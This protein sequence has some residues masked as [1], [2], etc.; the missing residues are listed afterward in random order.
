M[1][2]I[3]TVHLVYFTGTGGTA[4]VA[5][6]FEKAFSVYKVEVCK[7]KLEAKEYMEINADL[8]VLFFPVY[9]FNAPAPIDEWITRAPAGNGRAAAVISVS[10]GGEI[11]PNTAC[12]ADVIKQLA[13]K[14]YDVCYESMFVMPSNFIISYSDSLSAMLLRILPHKSE[15]VVADILSGK[16][17]RTKPY[18]IDRFLSKIGFIEK[19]Y[20]KTFGKKLKVNDKCVGCLWCADHC[21]RSNITMQ[22][23]QPTFGNRCVICLCC[24]YGCPQKAIVPGTGKFIVI[25]NGYD[26]KGVES[27]TNQLTEFPPLSKITNGFL[28]KGVRA[29]LDD[30]ENLGGT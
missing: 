23:E 13:G 20:G 25:K 12:R 27:R 9:A 14:G 2:N 15:R 19:Y 17:N 21:P 5:E 7:T 29:Y 24:V 4:R 28:L 3:K 18:F 10:G 11:S 6:S 26:L 8:L 30:D 1:I 22:D 16:R